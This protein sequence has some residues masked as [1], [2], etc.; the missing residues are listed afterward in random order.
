MGYSSKNFQ[1]PQLQ[2]PPQEISIAINFGHRI[3]MPAPTALEK[4][5][6]PIAEVVP[7]NLPGIAPICAKKKKRKKKKPETD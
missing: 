2:P 6:G 7:K 4:V 5:S 1:S 3:N